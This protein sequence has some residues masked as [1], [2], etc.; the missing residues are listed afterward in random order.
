VGRI[1]P[2]GGILFFGA[3]ALL[4]LVVLL[5]GYGLRVWN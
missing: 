5:A 4:T 3:L 1:G 2:L